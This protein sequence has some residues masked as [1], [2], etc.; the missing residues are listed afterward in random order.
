MQCSVVVGSGGRV[1]PT[2]SLWGELSRRGP[3]KDAPLPAAPLLC[4]LRISLPDLDFLRGAAAS[5][6]R[7]AAGPPPLIDR[8]SEQGSA[9]S[10][11]SGRQLTCFSGSSSRSG[12]FRGPRWVNLKDIGAEASVTLSSSDPPRSHEVGDSFLPRPRLPHSR[13]ELPAP[14]PRSPP[15]VRVPL[16]RFLRDSD[17]GP[18]CPPPSA[19]A[20]CPRAPLPQALRRRTSRA[21]RDRRPRSRHLLCP[22]ASPAR[23]RE[24]RS[25]RA[26]PNVGG[27]S[28]APSLRPDDSCRRLVRFLR[29]SEGEGRGVGAPRGQ[30]TAAATGSESS[31]GRVE[32]PPVRPSSRRTQWRWRPVSWVVPSCPSCEAGTPKTEGPSSL[33]LPRALLLSRGPRGSRVP[34]CPSDLPFHASPCRLFSCPRGTEFPSRSRGPLATE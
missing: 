22:S 32:D 7:S 18:C 25:W 10:Y 19:L 13:T 2:A 5:G 21:S 33:P 17:A 30:W 20:V 27:S 15:P 9:H 1:A 8:S 3:R 28:S 6:G 12:W 11:H 26:G 34:P 24:Q 16:P 31:G 4:R 23:L 29:L 14:V